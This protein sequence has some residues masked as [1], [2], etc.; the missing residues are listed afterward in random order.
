MPNEK[1]KDKTKTKKKNPLQ[2]NQWKLNKNDLIVKRNKP[3]TIKKKLIIESS[4]SSKSLSSSLKKR[5][6]SIHIRTR[7]CGQDDNNKLVK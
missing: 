2:F 4:S 5:S 7:S 1:K 6:K 3:K